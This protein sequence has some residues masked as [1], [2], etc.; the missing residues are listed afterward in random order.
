[1][2]A[3]KQLGLRIEIPSGSPVT[4]RSSG[5]IWNLEY[6]TL[7]GSGRP[8][9]SAEE[10]KTGKTSTKL[11]DLF[12]SSRLIPIHLISFRLLKSGE[13]CKNTKFV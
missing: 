13:N 10:G 7:V 8:R 11:I 3:P 5:Y 2:A 4:Y 6:G 9:A 12:H 1:M